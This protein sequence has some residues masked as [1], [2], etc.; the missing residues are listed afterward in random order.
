RTR[1]VTY[2]IHTDLR[3]ADGKALALK[4]G[5]AAEKSD[6]KKDDKDAKK[7]I[8]TRDDTDLA[9]PLLRLAERHAHDTITAVVLCSDGRHTSGPVPDD[10]ARA[11]SARG[12][13]LHTLGVG[14]I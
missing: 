12:I 2:N 4:E 7:T 3:S 10:A 1:I 8:S 14:S 9:T 5:E 11:L 6:D 13:A